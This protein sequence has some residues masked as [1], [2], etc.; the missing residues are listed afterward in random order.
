MFGH[1]LELFLH[2]L[3][4][5][6]GSED[7]TVQRLVHMPMGD[8]KLMVALGV[9]EYVLASPNVRVKDIVWTIEKLRATPLPWMVVTGVPL[10][11][12]DVNVKEGLEGLVAGAKSV[13]PMEAVRDL[14]WLETHRLFV[15][16]HERRAPLGEPETQEMV[17]RVVVEII[18]LY[19][20]Q[21]GRFLATT[22]YVAPWENECGER[23]LV[24]VWRSWISWF[25]FSLLAAH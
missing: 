24:V 19:Q 10:E 5:A 2:P 23:Q 15:R 21:T 12:S 7:T 20:V 3:L 8:W 14:A 22:D 25:R 6:R 16:P 13:L 18:K 9:C 1:K 17:E 4:W 11:L